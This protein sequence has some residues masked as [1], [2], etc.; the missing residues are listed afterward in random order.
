MTSTQKEIEVSYDVGNEFFRLWLDENMHYTCAVYEYPEQSLEAAQENKARILYDFAELGPDKTMLDIGCGWG[1]MMDYAVR[2]GIKKAEGVTLSTEQAEWARAR[3]LPKSEIHICDYALFTPAAKYD[4]LVSIEMIDHLCSPAQAQQG[5]AVEIYRKYFNKLAEW[6]EPGSCF[7][8]QAIL[9]N[10]LPRN[11]KDLEDLQFTADV[12][13]PGGLNPRIEDL[14]MAVN[15]R[16]EILEMHM[17]REDYGRTTGEWLRRLRLHEGEIR[18]RWGDQVFFD[19]VR[20]L[21]LC[22]RG[23][24]KHWSGDVQ[25]KLRRID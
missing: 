12:I 20:Y 4:G 19:Y 16:W 24:A 15:P 10:R 23:F 25:F 14:I 5:L 1:S 8:F 2:R 18:Q 13:F 17:R 7:G 9:R 21:D 11:R 6:V 22:V 3:N